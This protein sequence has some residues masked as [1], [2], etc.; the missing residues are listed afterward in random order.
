MNKADKDKL[1]REIAKQWPGEEV[2][3]VTIN[4]PTTE[5]I[6]AAIANALK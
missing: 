3:I 5:N 2:K 4:Q 1:E 6:L